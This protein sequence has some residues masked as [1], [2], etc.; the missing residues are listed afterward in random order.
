MKDLIKEGGGRNGEKN[1]YQGGRTTLLFFRTRSTHYQGESALKRKRERDKEGRIGADERQ[2][3][4]SRQVAHRAACSAPMAS[5]VYRKRGDGNSR[6]GSKRKNKRDETG[7]EG[8]IKSKKR[9]DCIFQLLHRKQISVKKSSS[10]GGTTTQKKTTR[11][12]R[13]Q[14]QKKGTGRSNWM[15]YPVRPL[16]REGLMCQRTTP[17][18]SPR[19][20]R[21]HIEQ[22]SRAL[23]VG[24][25]SL[26]IRG[27]VSLVEKE[28]KRDDGGG[29]SQK[30]KETEEGGLSLLTG[31]LPFSGQGGR[32]T[33]KN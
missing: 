21:P 10:T 14:T 22:G 11:R 2:K 3:T 15:G 1:E 7:E 16:D 9:E 30:R 18:A 20:K 27:R 31:D 6:E 17:S 5:R 26:G 29:A 4:Q 28:P 24:V 25:V 12:E 33:I 8:D 23:K 32:R 19:T 13:E